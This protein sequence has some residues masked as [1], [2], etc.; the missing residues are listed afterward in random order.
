MYYVYI[1]LS[2]KDHK[3]YIGFSNNIK[4]RI[5]KHFSGQVQS[6]KSRLPLKLIYYESFVSK[7][8]AL[9]EELFLKSGKGRERLKELLINSK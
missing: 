2:Q 8:D 1:L 5:K 3:L 4:E 7:T 6:T 9:R